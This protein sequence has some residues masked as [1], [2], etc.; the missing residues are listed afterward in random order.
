MVA[1]REGIVQ[2][3]PT[4]SR[5]ERTNSVASRSGI[6]ANGLAFNGPSRPIEGGS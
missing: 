3:L 6:G 2:E 1:Q 4:V 5:A